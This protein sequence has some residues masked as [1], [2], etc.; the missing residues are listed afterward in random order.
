MPSVQLPDAD[1]GGAHTTSWRYMSMQDVWHATEQSLLPLFRGEDDPGFQVRDLK[2]VGG[3]DVSFDKE[4]PSRAVGTLVVCQLPSLE[5]V[6]EVTQ[7]FTMTLPYVPGYL[8]ARETGPM[9][10]LYKLLQERGGPIPEV[11]LV[12]GNGVYHPRRCGSATCFGVSVDACTVGVAKKPF[13]FEG[14]TQESIRAGVSTCANLSSF[15]MP[16]ASSKSGEVLGVA[17][18]A[19][20]RT[21]KPIYVS[22]GHRISLAS[23]EAVVR[24]CCPHR[25][26]EPIRQADLRSRAMLK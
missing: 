25:I 14:I 23:A 9:V 13:E 16:L 20:K 11:M 5:V 4:D 12:D 2:H 19:G 24:L 1:S 3:V 21:R 7:S 10:Q 26:P 6:F 8:A 15:R 17:V 22:Q 18:C